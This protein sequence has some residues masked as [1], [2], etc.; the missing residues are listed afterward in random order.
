MTVIISAIR[1]AHLT[2]LIRIIILFITF[3]SSS[4]LASA[5]VFVL[6]TVITVIWLHFT[7]VGVMEVTIWATPVI[8]LKGEHKKY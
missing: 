6:E 2:G 5:F 1:F 8:R 3:L 4:P 7:S